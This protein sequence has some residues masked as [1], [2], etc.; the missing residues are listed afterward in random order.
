MDSETSLR[1]RPPVLVVALG[2]FAFMAMCFSLVPYALLA[3]NHQFLPSPK[4]LVEVKYISLISGLVCGLPTAFLLMS[5][6]PN[7]NK[8]S[9]T[10]NVFTP[11]F[12]TIMFFIL[13]HQLVTSLVPIIAA[14]CSQQEVEIIYAVNGRESINSRFCNAPITLDYM[15]WYSD[16]LCNFPPS[17]HQELSPGTQIV[18]AG[19]GTSWGLFVE[20]ARVVPPAVLP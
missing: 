14:I 20:S 11:A 12:A 3:L 10:F 2:L 6:S 16:Q 7:A 5:E 17:L 19:R 9:V 1:E 15:P 13:G 18:V 8:T 4:Y